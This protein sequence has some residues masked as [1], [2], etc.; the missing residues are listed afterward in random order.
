MFCRRAR[1][2]ISLALDGRLPPNRTVAL[3]EHLERCAACRAHRADLVVARRLLSA[4]APRLSERFEWRLQL[5]LNQT[6]R[7]AA[8]TELSPWARRQGGWQGWLGVAG[9]GAAASLALIMLALRLPTTIHQPRGAVPLAYQEATTAAPSPRE[10]ARPQAADLGAGEPE[11]ES[12][13]VTDTA[14]DPTRTA[15]G[16]PQRPLLWNGGAL[17]RTVD[18][19]G[20]RADEGR[21]FFPPA[22]WSGRSLEDLRMISQLRDE[23]QRLRLSLTMA[24][25]EVLLLKAQLDTAGGAR[26][27]RIEAAR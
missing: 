25:R 1:S 13:R 7:E 18:L 27:D 21:G 17:G 6:L 24:Q 19:G 22:A 26:D 20:G 11:R 8:R 14:G 15:L 4:T 5:R 12:L 16:S 9:F 2:W 23:N 10:G 3:E